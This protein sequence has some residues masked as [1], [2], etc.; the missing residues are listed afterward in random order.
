MKQRFGLR[1]YSCCAINQ[2]K[3]SPLRRSTAEHQGRRSCH[4]CPCS[5][6]VGTCRKQESDKF[7]WTSRGHIRSSCCRFG[8]ENPNHCPQRDQPAR[9]LSFRLLQQ[10]L[11][12]LSLAPDVLSWFE[13]G[14]ELAGR[15]CIFLIVVLVCFIRFLI[16]FFL[17]LCFF[18]QKKERMQSLLL[19]LL[20]FNL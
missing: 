19:N 7:S 16:L 1:C 13:Y 5:V 18:L 14:S 12:A 6:A 8:S 3:S 2:L 17:S 11:C 9:L 4:R 20:L 10:T 15:L